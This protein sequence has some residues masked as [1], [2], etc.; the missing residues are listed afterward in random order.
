MSIWSNEEG[1]VQPWTFGNPR[2]TFD[3]STYYL[4]RTL[5]GQHYLEV[6]RPTAKTVGTFA[7]CLEV[8]FCEL[9]YEGPESRKNL[10]P[11][12]LDC[13][14]IGSLFVGNTLAY[15][16]CTVEYRAAVGHHVFYKVYYLPMEKNEFY[17]A[18]LDM[19]IKLGERVLFPDSVKPLVA[20]PN[21][22][23]IYIRGLRSAPR[24]TDRDSRRIPHT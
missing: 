24:Y 11:V 16:L 19:L 9:A 1:T 21:F 13:D 12:F 10:Q 8:E 23:R 2:T 14:L 20:I 17:T 22:R 15:F 3:D 5:S 18:A 7:G 4:T 6:T